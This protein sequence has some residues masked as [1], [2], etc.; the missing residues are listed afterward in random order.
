MKYLLGLLALFLV[1]IAAHNLSTPCY[2]GSPKALT[3]Q[4]TREQEAPQ[5]MAQDHK[6]GVIIP[7]WAADSLWDDGKAEVSIYDSTRG[8]YG[9]ERSFETVLIVVKEDFNR[10]FMVKADWPYD[11]KD[12]FT[13]MKVNLVQEIETVAYPYRYMMSVF[14]PREEPINAVKMTLTAH[15]WC[16]NTFKE[17]RG[18]EDPKSIKYNSYWD[19]QGDGQHLLP[20]FTGVLEDQ[21]LYSLRSLN[22]T[23]GLEFKEKV[24]ESQINN[25]AN[26][27]TITEAHFKVAEGTGDWMVTVD[28]GGRTASYVFGKEYPNLLLSYDS[29]EGRTLTLTN[30]SRYSYWSI[31]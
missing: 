28:F 17:Y 11:G 13:V 12:V 25:K 10:E 6:P 21:L 31:E 19:G 16:G 23:D 2:A 1:V 14:T 24:L 3:T 4:E 8:V 29:G 15:E 9:S 22:F 30:T 7:S 20:G 5:A 26:E 18:W 27:P